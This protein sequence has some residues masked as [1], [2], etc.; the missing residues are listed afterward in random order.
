MYEQQYSGKHSKTQNGKKL[1]HIWAFIVP[2]L[3]FVDRAISLKLHTL[4]SF[5]GD[6]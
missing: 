6:K 5:S 1:G 2:S 4:S 3:S